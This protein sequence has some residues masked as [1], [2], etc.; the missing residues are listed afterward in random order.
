VLHLDP[1]SGAL[2]SVGRFSSVVLDMINVDGAPV[3]V[4]RAGAAIE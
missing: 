2:L 4:T 3:A 1:A